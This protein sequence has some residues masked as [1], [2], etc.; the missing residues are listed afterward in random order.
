MNK[1]KAMLDALMGPSRD[2]AQKDK[3]TDEFKDKNV[4]K[5][6]LVGCCPMGV[7]GK[8]L[9]AIRQ[10]PAAFCISPGVT[11][12]KPSVIPK[13]GCT[14]LHSQGLRTQLAEHPDHA[15]YQ[16]QY[17]EDLHSYLRTV[18]IEADGKA[19]HEKRKREALGDTPE[20]EKLCDVCGLRYKLQRKEYGIEVQDHHPDTDIHKAYMK[21]RAKLDTLNEKQKEWDTEDAKKEEEKNEKIENQKKDDA[22][23]EGKEKTHKSGRDRSRSRDRDR[24]GGERSGGNRGDRGGDRGDKDSAKGRGGRDNS[25]DRGRGRRSNSRDR[26]DR[27]RGGDR[28]RGR[29]DNQRSDRRSR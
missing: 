9:E 27:G 26:H 7:L 23:D 10:S 15:K 16:R 19:G 12:D 1:A 11:F 29:D 6:F 28:D 25:P 21:L 24:G 3:P 14:K 13:E 8:K 20:C 18:I 2:I 22:K 5:H 17:E 4:C